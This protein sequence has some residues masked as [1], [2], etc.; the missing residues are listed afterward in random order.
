MN[1]RTK[2]VAGFGTVLAATALVFSPIGA[3]AVDVD[4]LV[5][6]GTAGNITP[7]V[8]LVGGSGSYNFSGS[9][10]AWLSVDTDA[11][12]GT[13][14]AITSTG[15]FANTVCGTGTADGSATIS[16]TATVGANETLTISY[17]IQFVA[18]IGVLTGSSGGSTAAGVV[19]IVPTV[20]NCVT[21]VTQFL[22]NGAAGLAG[23]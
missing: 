11:E 1:L 9:C 23:A 13:V 21:P 5:F 4:A 17:H 6:T 3:K 22:V 8:Q 19:N 15:V 10:L 20:G 14:C 16:A 7:G 2:I 18:S 12:A